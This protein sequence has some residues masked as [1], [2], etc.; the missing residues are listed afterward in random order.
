MSKPWISIIIATY[1]ADEYLKQCLDSIVSQ[2]IFE[3]IELLIIDDGSTDG[4]SKI[5]SEYQNKYTNIV[6]QYQENQ[7]AGPARNNALELVHGS[8]VAYMDA[9]DYYPDNTCLEDLYNVAVRENA[10]MC[11]GNI[12]T[13]DNGVEKYRYKAGD[14]DDNHTQNG[15]INSYEYGSAYGHTRYLYSLELLKK[16]DIKYSKCKRYDDVIFVIDAI[17]S[18]KKIY[19]LDRDVYVVRVNHKSSDYSVYLW[20]DKLYGYR[21]A[22]AHLQQ[23][24]MQYLYQHTITGIIEDRLFS[25]IVNKRLYEDEEARRAIY[26]IENLISKPEWREYLNRPNNILE[27]IDSG[28]RLREELKSVAVINKC[29]IYG[30]G[31]YA[32]QCL[33]I[34]SE[35]V[36]DN[37]LGIAV[38]EKKGNPDYIDKVKVREIKEY[39]QN[40]DAYVIIAVSEKFRDGIVN[41]LNKYGFRKYKCFD[42]DFE[43]L[44][45]RYSV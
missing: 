34:I 25:V 15:F 14:M 45:S 17:V 1:N 26:E 37:I 10:L 31:N 8:F 2:S 28:L 35:Y 36:D 9:D 39:I 43:D 33:K 32:K 4:S 42:M 24:D 7:G 12:K 18:A 44:I 6:Y 29:I 16:N 22:I 11:G 27:Y 3:K 30:A 23:L 19:E 41:E 13:I 5:I 38:T 21:D 20:K 40:L